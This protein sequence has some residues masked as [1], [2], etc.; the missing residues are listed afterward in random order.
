MR[1]FKKKIEHKKIHSKLRTIFLQ[2]KDSK[3]MRREKKKV[4]NGTD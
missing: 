3:S 4:E 1:F 2:P